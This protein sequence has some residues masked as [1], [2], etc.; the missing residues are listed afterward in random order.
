MAERKENE[1]AEA[2]AISC[3][4]RRTRLYLEIKKDLRVSKPVIA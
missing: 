1:L 3:Y 4:L 2:A